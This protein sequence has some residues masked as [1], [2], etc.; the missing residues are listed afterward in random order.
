MPRTTLTA[1]VRAETRARGRLR[2]WRSPPPPPGEGQAALGS[3]RA[4]L[5]DPPSHPSAVA[6]E[7]L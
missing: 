6:A 3:A 2:A 1:S 4:G 7:D 5:G